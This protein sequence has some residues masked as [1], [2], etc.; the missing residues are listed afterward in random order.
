MIFYEYYLLFDILLIVSGLYMG[1]SYLFFV[2]TLRSY[3]GDIGVKIDNFNSFNFFYVYKSFFTLQNQKNKFFTFAYYG[4][5]ISLI[6]TL[7]LGFFLE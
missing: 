5:F 3:G 4:H 2:K 7:I 6:L 1:A